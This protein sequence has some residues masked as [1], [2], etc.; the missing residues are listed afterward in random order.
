MRLRD[1]WCVDIGRWPRLAKAS[2]IDKLFKLVLKI[3]KNIVLSISHLLL[4]ILNG[5]TLTN[6]ILQKSSHIQFLNTLE[7]YVDINWEVL[8]AIYEHYQVQELRISQEVEPRKYQSF[9]FQ[10]LINLFLQHRVKMYQLLINDLPVPYHQIECCLREPITRPHDSSK[11]TPVVKELPSIIVEEVLK[12]A[13]V[14]DRVK[15]DPVFLT[16]CP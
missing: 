3:F 14:K 9:H 16:L 4:F 13:A 2:Q 1:D 6:T 11:L 5:N 15:C 12:Q 10:E 7:K 8:I